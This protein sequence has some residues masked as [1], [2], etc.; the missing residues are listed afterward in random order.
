MDP[1]DFSFGAP[2]DEKSSDFDKLKSMFQTAGIEF[3]LDDNSIVVL[4]GN[5]KVNGV[6]GFTTYFN[7]DSDGKLVDINISE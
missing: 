2:A 6:A 7:F 3:E 4:A 5:R 1:D